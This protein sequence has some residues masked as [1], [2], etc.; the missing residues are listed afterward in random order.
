VAARPG[1]WDIYDRLVVGVSLA[2]V[3]FA[4]SYGTV[5]CVRGR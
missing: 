5:I 3:A 1:G 4:T 2:A